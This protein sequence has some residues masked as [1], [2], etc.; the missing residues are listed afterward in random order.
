[1]VLLTELPVEV[2]EELLSYL[3]GWSTQRLGASCTFLHSLTG[4]DRIWH[5][6]MAR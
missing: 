2:L 6:L 3:D 1:M 4:Q 5:R